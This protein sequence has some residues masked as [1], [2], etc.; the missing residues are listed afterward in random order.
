MEGRRERRSSSRIGEARKR[1]AV[2]CGATVRVGVG[3][4]DGL[5]ETVFFDER[6]EIDASVPGSLPR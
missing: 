1:A 5:G 4:D 2:D 3:G 6:A